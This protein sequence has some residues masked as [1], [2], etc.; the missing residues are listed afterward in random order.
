MFDNFWLSQLEQP[1]FTTPKC[2]IISKDYL[3]CIRTRMHPSIFQRTHLQSKEPIMQKL[4]KKAIFI[5]EYE[6]ML[7]SW[8]VKAYICFCFD[9]DDCFKD[10]IDDS[11]IAELA[12]LKSSQY[13]FWCSFRQ[14]DS[15]WERMLYDGKY[16]TDEEFL[17]HFHMDQS[18]VM[19]LNRLVEDDQ[20]FRSVS[21]KWARDHQCFISWCC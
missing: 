19:Q 10:E 20:E 21:G 1:N 9:D 3:C 15:N 12:V 6:A 4:S 11:I 8:V 14:W 7:A 16:Q 17:S 18:C 2:M 5:K 13:I